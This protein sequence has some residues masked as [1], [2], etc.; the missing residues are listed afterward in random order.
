MGKVESNQ[1][2]EMHPLFPSGEWEGF[3]TYVMGPDADKHRM[4]CMLTFK[5]GTVAGGG[6]DDIGSFTWK[7]SYD[8]EQLLCT[9]TKQ[10]RTHSVFYQGQV[11]E[12]GIWGTWKVQR[13][14]GGFHIWPK[15]NAQH[16]AM[17][18]EEVL[19]EVEVKEQEVP[20][21]VPEK[22]ELGSSLF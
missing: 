11:D 16:E 8:T 1:P 4:Q 18:A 2:S 3:Y 17:Q 9:M 19:E 6:S 14:N 7:G 5:N 21:V 13:S 15:A 22:K 12:N 20:V 10:Y